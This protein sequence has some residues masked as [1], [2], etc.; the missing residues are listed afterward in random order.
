MIINLKLLQVQE[1]SPKVTTG[2]FG[3]NIDE[4]TVSATMTA[5][6]YHSNTN[7]FLHIHQAEAKVGF[8]KIVKFN[9]VCKIRHKCNKIGYIHV[10]VSSFV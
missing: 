7:S 9:R 3:V 10:I 6:K 5:T 1:R 4:Q 2:R 8:V